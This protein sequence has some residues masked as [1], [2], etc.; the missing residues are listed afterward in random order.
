MAQRNRG[1]PNTMTQR[2]LIILGTLDT[3]GPEIAFLRDCLHFSGWKTRIVD[4]GLLGTP[5]LIPEVNREEVAARAGKTIGE[6]LS[7]GK[8]KV[9]AVDTMARGALSYI[10]EWLRKGEVGGVIA[11]GG[12][13]GTWLGTTVMRAL[14]LGLPKVMVSTIPFQDIRPILGT[15]DIVLFP[16]VADILGLNPI[17]RTIIRNAASAFAAMAGLSPLVETNK[18]VIGSTSLGITTPAVLASRRILEEHGFEM[19]CFHANG[20]GGKA[21][22]EAIRDGLFSGVL[23]LTTHEVTNQLFHGLSL[24]GED[25]LEAAARKGIPQVVAP[26]GIDVISEG[27]IEKLSPEQ[28]K[29]PHYRHSPFF[30]HVRVSR[31]EMK[32]VGEVMAS[33][34]NL[35]QGPV[36]VA[37]P[38][39]GF[40]DRNRLGDLFYDPEADGEFLSSLK[41]SL[42]PRVR[43]IEVDAHINDEPFA[44]RV[45]ELLIGMMETR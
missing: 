15:K 30:T 5:A 34:L 22:E 43:V 26:G 3:K 35:G 10:N 19:T 32:Q 23:D 25:R 40:S 11:L 37:V 24:A 6:L 20:Y 39:R 41:R 13:V 9:I 31:E 12:G 17:L 36:A 45:C 38:L 2:Y 14:P 16:S 33:K 21:L 42:D 18:E 28:R 44:S 8:D 4:A 1:T 7:E 27:P 29:R